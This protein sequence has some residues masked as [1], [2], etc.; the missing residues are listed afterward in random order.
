MIDTSRYKRLNTI[1]KDNLIFDRN[2]HNN[3]GYEVYFDDSSSNLL[4]SPM[5]FTDEEK[6]LMDNGGKIRVVFWIESY[7]N[8]S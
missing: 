6:K 2:N 8:E 5:F 3:L 1:D 7:S 4:T